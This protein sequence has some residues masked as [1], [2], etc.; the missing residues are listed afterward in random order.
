MKQA[1]KRL[2]QKLEAKHTSL[3]KLLIGGGSALT[4]AHNIPLQTADIDAVPFK[5][6]VDLSL[7]DKLIK[8]TG[9][10]LKISPDWLNPYFGTFLM[11][12]PSDY[13]DR[14]IDV[15]KGKSLE[16]YG[17]GLNDLLIMKC[18][19]GREKDI[20]HSKVLIRKGA[21]IDFVQDHIESLIAKNIP[22]AQQALHCLLE[23]EDQMVDM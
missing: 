15:Y 8:E 13:G 9:K 4:L 19:A 23:V 16:A 21:N 10:E 5:S 7:L 17:L 20:P 6:N 3:L 22:G 2:D 1:L 14:L 11:S 18:F 12:L